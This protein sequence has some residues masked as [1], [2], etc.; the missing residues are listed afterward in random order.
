MMFIR[1]HIDINRLYFNFLLFLLITISIILGSQMTL[2]EGN[3]SYIV[4][5]LSSSMSTLMILLNKQYSH[6]E[7]TGMLPS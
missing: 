2:N 6:M 1:P 5:S 4:I 7:Q 3:H